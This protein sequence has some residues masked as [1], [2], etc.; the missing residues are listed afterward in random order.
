MKLACTAQTTVLGKICSEILAP[1]DSIAE[2]CH[3]AE[4]KCS[5]ESEPFVGLQND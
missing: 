5:V 2:E 4:R 1:L 3:L